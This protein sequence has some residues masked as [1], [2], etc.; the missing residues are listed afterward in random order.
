[1]S[2]IKNLIK[3]K[4][5][6]RLLG[7]L[8]YKCK[9]CSK[10]F[11]QV[12]TL[13]THIHTIHEGHKDHKCKACGKSFSH[14]IS[15][16]K[17]TQTVHSQISWS[18]Q[19]WSIYHISMNVTSLLNK[20]PMLFEKS[21]FWGFFLIATP[22]ITL[23]VKK[24]SKTKSNVACSF[25]Y[26]VKFYNNYSIS[27]SKMGPIKVSLCSCVTF[28][29]FTQWRKSFLWGISLIWLCDCGDVE[30]TGLNIFWEESHLVISRISR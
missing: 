28:C 7:S 13:K 29:N 3:D 15:L 9:S 12:G 2:G 4:Y 30:H 5:P 16:K 14:A 11:S 23:F 21:S 25:K 17:H 22:Q 24:H 27:I 6:G 26:W 18:S 20:N 19:K 1:M 10:S 8:E